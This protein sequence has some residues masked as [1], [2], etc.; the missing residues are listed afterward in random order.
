MHTY[1]KCLTFPPTDHLYLQYRVAQAHTHPT[2]RHRITLHQPRQTASA[3]RPM[4]MVVPQRQNLTANSSNA[5][6]RMRRSRLPMR[7]RQM[8]LPPH[9]HM[10]AQPP[11]TFP[12]YPWK[13]S[14]R[15]RCRQRGK[16]RAYFSSCVSARWSMSI[17]GISFSSCTIC[18][19]RIFLVL[20]GH[21]I[22]SCPWDLVIVIRARPSLAPISAYY[23]LSRN[24]ELAYSVLRRRAP[25]GVCVYVC[26]TVQG[27]C[28]D[29]FDT[30]HSVL[31]RKWNWMT[32]TCV[33]IQ[34]LPSFSPSLCFSIPDSPLRVTLAFTSLCCSGAHDPIS[35]EDNS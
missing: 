9:W 26:G 32:P 5:Q 24:L 19:L 28:E 13:A 10:P 30:F 17:L 34:L 6:N 16:W 8:Q 1:E 31:V 29:L 23:A 14:C 18:L 33:S 7:R 11:P 2:S 3:R 27:R 25:P 35:R 22:L 20:H 15:Q 12:S 21:Q 4:G